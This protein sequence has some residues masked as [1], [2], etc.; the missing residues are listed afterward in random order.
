[1]IS[2]SGNSIEISGYKDTRKTY[3]VT[4][5]GALKD[6]FGQSLGH[7]VS[8]SFSV[9]ADE[10]KLWSEGGEF[11][12]LDPNGKPAFFVYSENYKNLD[13]KLY[14]VR[15]EDYGKFYNLKQNEESKIPAGI[16]KLVYD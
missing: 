10:P 4:V 14:A 13:V 7:E 9:D 3:K 1:V 8:T 2:V 15:A 11:V 16:G 12:T 6:E 5:S